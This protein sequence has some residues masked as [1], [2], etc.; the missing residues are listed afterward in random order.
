L[1]EVAWNQQCSKSFKVN[2][3]RALPLLLKLVCS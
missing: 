2:L 1:R 3:D